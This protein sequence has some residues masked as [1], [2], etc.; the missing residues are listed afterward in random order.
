MPARNRRSS[1]FG[2][3]ARR[4][5]VWATANDASIPLAAGAT[6]GPFDLLSNLE[7]AGSSILGATIVRAHATLHVNF[8]ASDTAP[9]V[10]VGW[11]VDTAPP[12]GAD[13]I[14]P[15]TQLGLDWQLLRG[16]G[17]ASSE[18]AGTINGLTWFCAW[19][20]DLKGKRKIHQ[21]GEKYFFV[22]TNAGTAA[23]N[24]TIWQRSLVMLP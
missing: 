9:F 7:V 3:S 16:I 21:L 1:S 15:Q 6:E 12:T 8:L 17:P 23:I 14:N 19:N 18:G 24:Y 4:K 20:I 11:L 22:I 5:T 2:R 10:D 13:L